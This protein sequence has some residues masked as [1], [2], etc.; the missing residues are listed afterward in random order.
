M[1]HKIKNA[2][3][4]TYKSYKFEPQKG[5]IIFT[6]EIEFD[7]GKIIEFTDEIILP[8][9]DYTTAIQ[10][11]DK[12]L[13][14]LLNSLHIMLGISYYKLFIPPKVKLNH[15]ITEEQADFFNTV[16]RKGLG[17][18]CYRNKI[19]PKRIVK[20]SSRI[21]PASVGNLRHSEEKIT[22]PHSGKVV[23]NRILLGIAGGK[24]S[25]VAGELLK[26]QGED[27]TG[28]ILDTHNNMQ[29][30]EK[31]AKIMGLKTLVIQHKLDAK[32]YNIPE[33]FK[34]H[35]P[36]SAMLAFLGTLTA[37]LY[38]YSY[39][40][41]AN[42][43]SA[44]FGNIKYKTNEIYPTPFGQNSVNQMG[45]I[46]DNTKNKL[47]GRCGINHQW[48]KTSEFEGMMQNYAHKYISQDITYFSA[49]RPFYEIRAVEIFSRYKKYFP[50]FTSCNENFK[51]K[52]ELEGGRAGLWCGKCPKCVFV[53][54]LLSVFITTK[55]LISI[56]KKFFFEDKKLLPVFKDL[57]G[58][59]Q[60]KPFDCVGT[61]EEMRAAFLMASK[62]YKNT[63]IIKALSNKVAAIDNNR[64]SS[65]KLKVF[66]TQTAPYLPERFKFLGVKNILI[67]GY[68]IEGKATHQYLMSKYGNKIK[69]AIADQKNDKNY[70]EKQENFDL[71][72]KTPG[73]PKK[74]IRRPYTTATNIFFS[75]IADKNII[76]IG[77][78]GSKG[79]STTASL[80]YSILKEAGK[81]VKL[82]GNIGSS[83][84]NSITKSIKKD[85]IFVLE[86]SSYQLDDIKF[87]PNI[88]V[89]LNLF[90][91]HMPYHGGIE[92]Y[93]S[94]KKNII[95]FQKENDI[96]IYNF[97]NKLFKKWA[98]DAY[99]AT[100][101][102]NSIKNSFLETK[103]LIGEHNKEN[104]KAAVTV[105]KLFDIKDNIIRKAI[106]KFNS[107]P[108]RLEFAGNFKGI[109]FYNDSISTAPESAIAGI[110]ALKDIGTIILGGEDRGYDFTEL[111]KIIKKYKINNIVLFPDTGKR[112]L[113]SKKGFNILE[114]SSMEKAVQFAYANT[115]KNSICLLSPASPSHNLWKNFEERGD[116]Y[117]RWVKIGATLPLTEGEI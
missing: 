39:V 84:L 53:F 42:E 55:E 11:N 91:D 63:V 60:L 25:I 1:I 38:G 28:F 94:A 103:N 54:T 90:P 29:I 107:L 70:L 47:P 73:I 49:L 32:I 83:M 7:N 41:M 34:G 115:P 99:S 2:K 5:K 92:Q 18:F 109:K 40:A 108:H 116:E 102:F 21:S 58:L 22:S 114:T 89:I 36:F 14:A 61:F 51:L 66:K 35:I 95:N 57:L 97:K 96:F 31:I 45:Q 52:S 106:K 24:D 43:Y 62:K 13:D 59:G 67:L 75:E 50:Y 76:T 12:K 37:Y 71:I 9:K 69:I 20:F 3:K 113:K 79:K 68:G 4:I 82:V 87:S 74:L 101:P 65:S 23:T 19:N 85:S 17:E 64:D 15:T 8:N 26:R 93:Y 77:I 72:I 78:T 56:F 110:E 80:I 81:T 104:I 46:L 98:K 86:L 44:N 16:Y 117:V 111:E 88:A 33:S 48:S 105:V 100:L 10:R 6:Y 30:P 27:I 112:I